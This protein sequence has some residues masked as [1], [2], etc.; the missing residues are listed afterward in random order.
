MY[1]QVLSMS[2][3]LLSRFVHVV[4]RYCQDLSMYD[5]RYYDFSIMFLFI[6][7]IFLILIYRYCQVSFHVNL[8][9]CQDLSM[10]THPIVKI[11]PCLFKFMFFCDTSMLFHVIFRR[12]RDF[13][14]LIYIIFII[15]LCQTLLFFRYFVL[16]I[17]C[18]HLN[19]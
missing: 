10:L 15:C 9:C 5:L 13:F 14:L 2:F 4:L 12:F 19:Y 7:M 11:F 6:F 3:T 18:V 16:F 17:N 8:R 1:C